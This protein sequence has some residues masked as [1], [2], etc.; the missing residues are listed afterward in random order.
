MA[1]ILPAGAMLEM[2]FCSAV[3]PQLGQAGVLPARTSIS[4]GWPQAWQW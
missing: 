1:S 3:L 4:N 2:H